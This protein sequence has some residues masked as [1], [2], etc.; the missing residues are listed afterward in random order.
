MDRGKYQ[1]FVMDAVWRAVTV[2]LQEGYESP[3][4][5]MSTE[6]VRRLERMYGADYARLAFIFIVMARAGQGYGI[7]GLSAVYAHTSLVTLKPA[8]VTRDSF[9]RDRIEAIVGTSHGRDMYGCS[10]ITANALRVRAETTHMSRHGK[11][12]VHLML[13]AFK[14]MYLYTMQRTHF[15]RETQ[16]TQEEFENGKT[17]WNNALENLLVHEHMTNV[18]MVPTL[19]P[20]FVDRTVALVTLAH[21]QFAEG[22]YE[23]LLAGF[24]Q[25]AVISGTV[26]VGDFLDI[27]YDDVLVPCLPKRVASDPTFLREM[28]YR[29]V[30]LGSSEV[31]A[32]LPMT[33]R[34][35][36]LAERERE[37]EAQRAQSEREA[38]RAQITMFGCLPA[39]C[40]VP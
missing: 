16:P 8:M 9:V 1:P 31:D 25:S 30:H 4:G 15:T 12:F 33:F 23:M 6:F 39:D 32:F 28:H 27:L 5:F 21:P 14:C 18:D 11:R 24:D 37:R 22:L 36:F 3:E 7:G 38:Q 20:T 19:V 2:A 13:G 34:R 10:I 17:L 40:A 29:R 35:R 26:S